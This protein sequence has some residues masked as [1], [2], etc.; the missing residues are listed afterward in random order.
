MAAGI[1]HFQSGELESARRAFEAARAAGLE[2]NSLMYN[3]GVVYYRLGEYELATNA[4]SALLGTSSQA[5][6][7]YNLGLVAKAAGDLDK[8]AFW[9][10]RAAADSAPEKIRA[11]AALQL[12]EGKQPSPEPS[13][14][15]WMAYVSLA[16]GYDNNI[17]SV[18]GSGSSGREGGFG[19]LLA[20]GSADVYRTKGSTVRLE[21]A[22]Y[23]RQYPSESDFD[24]DFLQ[25]G[26]SWLE[27]LGPGRAGVMLGVSQSWFN[28]EALERTYRVDLSYRLEECPVGGSG[29]RCRA[30]VSTGVV[31]GGDGFEAYD[32]QWYQARLKG[33]KDYTRWRVDA[34][35]RWDL[36]ARDDMEVG[37]QFVS[38]SPERNLF[39]LT[40]RYKVSQRW[41]VGV[42]GSYRYSR[43]RDPHRLFTSQ[44]VLESERRVDKRSQGT[45][46][47]EY[48][49]SAR[50]SV[51]GEW[52]FRDNQSNLA[53]YDYRRQTALVGIE[54]VF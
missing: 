48:A 9:F 46:L 12:Q 32:G 53:R 37:E 26:T 54:G 30:S 35:Y 17:A 42:E 22:A 18:P 36:N 15:P 47:T 4:F 20:A 14:R 21:G 6:A 49:L 1:E 31:E 11:L 34:Q 25:V 40:V 29:S 28:S 45:L 5:L 44:G 33:R 19:E 51:R 43:Y 10:N 27:S 13:P 50:W 3:L 2:S 16:G 23:S 41:N 39:E 8:A 7:E 24:T 52:M 38:V